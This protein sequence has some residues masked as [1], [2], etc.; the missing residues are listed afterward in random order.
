MTHMRYT[1]T[2]TD[3]ECWKQFGMSKKTIVDA[4]HLLDTLK[5]LE[6]CI[7]VGGDWSGD[8]H[9]APCLRLKTK[10]GENLHLYIWGDAEM[11]TFG[12]GELVEMD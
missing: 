12:Y 11:N 2:R 1:E 7:V 9:T 6:G 4:R 5:E 8:A 10:E 3:S